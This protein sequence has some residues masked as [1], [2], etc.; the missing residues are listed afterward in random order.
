MILTENYFCRCFD[1]GILEFESLV[2]ILLMLIDI[3][4]GSINH[5]F[6]KKDNVSSLALRSIGEKFTISLIVIALCIVV[7]LNDTHIFDDTVTD[8]INGY[9]VIAKS[10]I[11]FV[12]YYELTSVCKHI[13]IMT[14]LDLTKF[15][16][17]LKSELENRK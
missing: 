7:H 16:K 11:V 1:M 14:G 3:A 4:L 5:V 13:Q 10:V 6:Y 9:A 2:T 15:V 8:L 12:C 17:G